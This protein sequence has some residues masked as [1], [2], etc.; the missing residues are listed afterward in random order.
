MAARLFR[1]APFEEGREDELR[2][3]YHRILYE[4]AGFHVKTF[5]FRK[6]LYCCFTRSSIIGETMF[7][8]IRTVSVHAFGSD[9]VGRWNR[10]AK[11]KYDGN[12]NKVSLIGNEMQ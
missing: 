7:L 9:D 11:S 3:T 12:E 10:N 6:N 8:V 5:Y 1:R 4:W 2:G